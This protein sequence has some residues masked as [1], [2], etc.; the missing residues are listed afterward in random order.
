[1][2]KVNV[3]RKDKLICVHLLWDHTFVHAKNRLNL[4]LVIGQTKVIFCFGMCELN[5]IIYRNILK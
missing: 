4:F 3:E 2:S 5:A 1:M